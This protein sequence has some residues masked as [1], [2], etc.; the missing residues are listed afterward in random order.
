MSLKNSLLEEFYKLFSFLDLVRK[1][2]IRKGLQRVIYFKREAIV[3]ERSLANEIPQFAHGHQVRLMDGRRED[4]NEISELY[5]TDLG[6]RSRVRELNRRNENLLNRGFRLWPIYSGDTLIGHIWWL[7]G[8]IDKTSAAFRYLRWT[9]VSLGEGEVYLDLLFI[10]SRFR[11]KGV[12]NEVMSA[13]LWELQRREIKKAYTY[14][15]KENVPSL[16]LIKVFGWTETRRVY[17]HRI[18]LVEAKDGC[19]SFISQMT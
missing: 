14:V 13:V 2:G 8:P 9:K 12:A 15:L 4:L 3:F 10:S 16:W 19:L 17:F 18:F 11:G 7:Q 5:E 1:F 6:Y